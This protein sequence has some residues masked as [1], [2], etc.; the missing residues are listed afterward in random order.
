MNAF[1]TILLRVESVD[2]VKNAEVSNQDDVS[3]NVVH[4]AIAVLP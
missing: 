1:W 2:I 4:E 3:Q